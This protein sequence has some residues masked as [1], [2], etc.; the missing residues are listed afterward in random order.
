MTELTLLRL[1][2]LVLLLLCSSL[3]FGQPKNANTEKVIYRYKNDQGVLVLDSKI[4]PE[5]ARKGYDVLSLS[6][7]LLKTVPPALAGEAAEKARQAR[8]A[9]EEQARIDLQLRRSYSRVEDIAAA[10]ERNLQSL[11]GNIDIL[12][13][14]LASAGQ[15]LV[16]AQ[17]RAAGVERSGREVPADMLKSISDLEQEERDIQQQIQQ[18]EA[19]Y[20]QMSAKFDADLQRFIEINKLAPQAASQ[21]SP[22]SSADSL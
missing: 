11:R 4:P 17:E 19:E 21:S 10:K 9:K 3:A 12:Q 16:Q 15:R 2:T 1:K 14:N 6:G 22:A 5:F 18:R 7:K 20:Q 13:A 8:L